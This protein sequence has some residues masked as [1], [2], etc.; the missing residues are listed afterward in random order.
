IDKIRKFIDKAEQIA[1]AAGEAYEFVQDVRKR[2][3][4]VVIV[5]KIKEKLTN[6]WDLVLD[7]VK[8]FVMDQIIN[9]AIQKVLSMLDPT[10]IMAVINSAIALY[11]AIQSFIRYLRQMLEIVNSFVE[12]TL[13]IA[14]GATKKAANFLENSI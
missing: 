3:F 2:G 14:K 7:S 13:E 1:N 10:G 9:K 8:S 6:V 12:G 11:K 5:E 4:M